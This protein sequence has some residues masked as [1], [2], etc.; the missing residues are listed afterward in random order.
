MCLLNLPSPHIP[1]NRGQ[2]SV[3]HLYRCQLQHGHQWYVSK[4]SALPR[5]FP[6]L[7]SGPPV[8]GAMKVTYDGLI[9]LKMSLTVL[10]QCMKMFVCIPLLSFLLALFLCVLFLC[11]WKCV[12]GCAKIRNMN[13]WWLWICAYVNTVCLSIPLYVPLSPSFLSGKQPDGAVENNQNKGKVL[14]W[15][16][17]KLT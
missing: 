6:Q 8:H 13:C 11:L 5:S 4:L 15:M 17:N 1:P 9:H 2:Y 12:I 16:S 14:V 7:M 10:T 3:A